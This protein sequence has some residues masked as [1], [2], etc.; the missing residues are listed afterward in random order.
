MTDKNLIES[1]PLQDYCFCELAPLYAID[2]LT[3][4]ERQWVEQQ[5][6]ECPELAVEL[7]EYQ[8][9]VTAIPYGV[10]ALPAVPIDLKNRL[11]DQLGFAPAEVNPTPASAAKIPVAS[12]SPFFTVRSK[13][14]EWIPHLVPSVKVAILH[15]DEERRERVGLL[16][17][18][19]GMVYPSHRH[20]GVEEIYMLSGDLELEGITYYSG[21]Y[22]R[23]VA[24]SSHGIARSV[25]GCTFFFRSSMDD[26]YPELSL[27]S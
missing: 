5:V 3:E 1:L 22:I 13:E 19:P 6:A 16:E 15:S 11:F 21:D 7:A 26:E 18:D 20:G 23:S 4:A 8:Q 27:C 24:G 10:E 14:L 12:F 17:A 9:A 2:M 25:T